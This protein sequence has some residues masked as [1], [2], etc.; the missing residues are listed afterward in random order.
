M[1]AFTDGLDLRECPEALAASMIEEYAGG[2]GGTV[3][4]HQGQ[5]MGDNVD[6]WVG[7]EA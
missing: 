6:W 4:G 2:G 5:A 7:D 1:K 3:G